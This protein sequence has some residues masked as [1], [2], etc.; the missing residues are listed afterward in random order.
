M[1][2][3][4]DALK[5]VKVVKE[6]GK[7]VKGIIIARYRGAKYEMPLSSIKSMLEVPIIGIVPEDKAV[8]QSLTKRDTVVHTHPRSK[9]A[10]KYNEIAVKI[11]GNN[12]E[13]KL[14]NKNFLSRFFDFNWF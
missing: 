3:V 10:R 7:Q 5:A 11:L 12:Y 13:K 1:P 9:A 4:T 6:S 2:A 14:K 8:K